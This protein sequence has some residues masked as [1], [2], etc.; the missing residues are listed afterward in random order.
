MMN[1]DLSSAFSDPANLPFLA[2]TMFR[3][4]HHYDEATVDYCRV[5]VEEVAKGDRRRN[6]AINHHRRGSTPDVGRRARANPERVRR[7]LTALEV[8]GPLTT[9]ALGERIQLGARQMLY[10]LRAMEKAD[11]VYPVEYQNG[12]ASGLMWLLP[13]DDPEIVEGAE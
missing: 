9:R 13:D 11:L 2:A 12:L 7:V 5:Q 4:G 8:H 10:V 6:A 3:F 1:P